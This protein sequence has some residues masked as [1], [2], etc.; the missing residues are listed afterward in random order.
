MMADSAVEAL[1]EVDVCAASGGGDRETTKLS[2]VLILSTEAG[3]GANPRHPAH[4]AT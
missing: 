3:F 1:R 4:V 2:I